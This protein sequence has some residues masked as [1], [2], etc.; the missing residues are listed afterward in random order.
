M[1]LVADAGS[2]VSIAANAPLR[3]VACGH[4]DSVRRPVLRANGD[5]LPFDLHR[6]DCCGLVQQHPRYSAARLAKLYDAGYYVF[7]EAECHRWAR[8]AQ[9]Y[10]VH[11]LPLESKSPRRLLDIGCAHGHLCALARSRGWRV[12]GL[13]ISADAVS[14]AS[15]QFGLD[16][17]AGSLSQYMSSLP[18]FDVIFL[19]DVIEHVEKPTAFMKDVREVLSPGGVV[20]IDTPN[21]GGRW[22]RLGRSHWLG[23][24][25][26]HINLFD[27]N[28]IRRLLESGGFESVNT[29]AY[30]HYR[31]ATWAARPEIQRL[32]RPFPDA[33]TW[34][35]NAGL[36]TLSRK[37]DW[38]PL[39]K[40]PP[41]DQEAALGAVEAFARSRRAPKFAG[42]GDNLVA[43]GRRPVAVPPHA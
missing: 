35:L 36:A 30:T 12:N 32:T 10:I 42:A 40:Q 6:C 5:N 19:G 43:V 41:Q 39:R 25:R 8:A 37:S 9:Q 7:K 34:R 16:V 31:Y 33:I 14:H 38:T 13:D 27:A 15:V 28:S 11:L 20:S 22:R 24:N 21:W 1:T 18:R 2:V 17:R 26:F 4:C 3:C 23:L 29:K